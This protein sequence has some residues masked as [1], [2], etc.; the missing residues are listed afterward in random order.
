L[1]RTGGF[2]VVPG[3]T[4][5]VRDFQKVIRA[6]D[7]VGKAAKKSVRD[8]LK[9]AADPVLQTA[10]RTSAPAIRNLKEGSP[11]SKQRIGVTQRV[12]YMAPKVRGR[13]KNIRRPNFRDL[14]MDR[15]YVPSLR[16]N[17]DEVEKR[18]GSRVFDDLVHEWRVGA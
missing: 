15:V 7:R 17:A 4:V 9:F 8:N 1:A 11:W 10:N 18:L 6:Y 16:V 14:M 5:N 13:N 2:V 3:A 12:V